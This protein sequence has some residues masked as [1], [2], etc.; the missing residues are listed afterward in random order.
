MDAKPMK[1]SVIP[2]R[3]GDEVMRAISLLDGHR[4]GTGRSWH[5]ARPGIRQGNQRG[6]ACLARPFRLPPM[7]GPE[8]PFCRRAG[9]SPAV[10]KEGFTR[11]WVGGDSVFIKRSDV[12]IDAA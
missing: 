5:G 7:V 1:A 9:A 8:S 10:S 2:K 11:A 12:A 6:T 4:D 3:Q